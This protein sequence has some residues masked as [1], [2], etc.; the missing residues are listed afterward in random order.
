MKKSSWKTDSERSK[1]CHQKTY[2]AVN[3]SCF[4]LWFIIPSCLEMW[5]LMRYRVKWYSTS[6]KIAI[7]WIF[8]HARE[9]KHKRNASSSY[10]LNI[11]H[12]TAHTEWRKRYVWWWS[13]L[14]LLMSFDLMW[15]EK[16]D[17]ER[18]K[19]FSLSDKGLQSIS[20]LNVLTHSTLFAVNS[21]YLWTQFQ[22]IF[23]SFQWVYYAQRATCF[24]WTMIKCVMHVH[25]TAYVPNSPKAKQIERW[26]GR[27]VY[28]ILSSF[29]SYIWVN[30]KCSFK[31]LITLPLD[32]VSSSQSHQ[33][34][35]F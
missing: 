5:V 2:I 1:H 26:V 28:L 17:V 32:V 3:E 21:D 16:K 12:H 34:H 29:I 4:N 13:T 6:I 27:L 24:L 7:W 23:I 10:I 18:K 25:A 33:S 19:P 11:Y 30:Q 35:D 20:L 31:E 14:L 15:I 22:V 8:L 9:R